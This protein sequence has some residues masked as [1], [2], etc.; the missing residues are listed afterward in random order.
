MSKNKKLYIEVEWHPETAT[1]FTKTGYQLA[2]V[3]ECCV[4]DVTKPFK[5]KLLSGEI[6]V[7]FNKEMDAWKYIEKELGAR[8]EG[9]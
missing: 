3:D 9:V 1:L 5:A 7:P 4:S 8:K 2:Y 6:C